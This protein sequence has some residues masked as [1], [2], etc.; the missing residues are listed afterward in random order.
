MIVI[1]L[2]IIHFYVDMACVYNL[3]REFIQFLCGVIIGYI[4]CINQYNNTGETPNFAP[5]I[6][7]IGMVDGHQT[8]AGIR[9]HHW[10]WA[11]V[12]LSL[13]LY[14][15]AYLLCGLCFMFFI[16]GLSYIDCFDL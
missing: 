4:I 6:P 14:Y 13:A 7:C 9:I 15:N 5:T 1:N 2:K 11:I 8:I 10:M 16:H 12:F 3:W